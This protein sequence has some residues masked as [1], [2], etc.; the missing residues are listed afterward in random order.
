MPINEDELDQMVGRPWMHRVP[1]ECPDCGYNLTGLLSGVCPECGMP[2]QRR[3]VEQQ[4]RD[5]VAEAW[6]LKGINDVAKAALI[7]GVVAAVMMLGMRLIGYPVAARVIG[8][9]GGVLAFG[10]GLSI[11]RAMRV[12]LELLEEMEGKPNYPMG[13]AAAALGAV[14]VGLAVVMP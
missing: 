12:P 8:F 2:V 9:F 6:R 3:V 7:I 10:L 5:V 14:L 4:A 1:P 11:L 13:I